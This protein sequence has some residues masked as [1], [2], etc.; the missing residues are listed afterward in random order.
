MEKRKKKKKEEDKPN[1]I[2]K[3]QSYRAATESALLLL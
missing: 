1:N 2:E 3:N